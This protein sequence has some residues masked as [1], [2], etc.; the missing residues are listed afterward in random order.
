LPVVGVN[1]GAMP[2]RVP[3]QLGRLGPVGDAAAMAD[4]IALLWESKQ[5]KQMA[6]DARTHVIDNF[7][8]QKTFER[9]FEHIYP[10]AMRKR[11]YVK[12]SQ[13]ILAK[14]TIR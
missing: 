9:L 10:K 2:A 11:P 12:E 1:A 5:I 6:V 4:H 13:M 14:R 8:W 3:P 7:S